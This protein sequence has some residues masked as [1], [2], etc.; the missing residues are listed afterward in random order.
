MLRKI[1]KSV[2]DGAVPGA[3]DAFIWDA[4]LKGFGL[5]VTPKGR[6]VYLV[7]YRLPDGTT[8]RYT[9]GVHGSPWTPSQARAEAL[10]ILGLAQTGIDPAAEKRKAKTDISVSDLCERYKAEGG[11]TKKASTRIIES[12]II[13]LHIKPLL[14]RKQVRAL[15]KADI[16]RF[17]RDVA[18]GKTAH[19]Q[20]TGIR[21]RSIV[22]GGKSAAN[23]TLGLLSPMLEFAVDEGLRSDNPARGVKKFREGRPARFLSDQELT[24]TGARL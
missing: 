23:R 14:G 21:G 17:M 7:Q 13:E 2:V 22:T 1:T 6:R 4:E 18:E 15:T 3:R 24:C 5:K 8:R 19:D 20:K 12:R 9:I 11:R 10:R 16:D